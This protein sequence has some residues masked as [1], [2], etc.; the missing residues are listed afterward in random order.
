EGILLLSLD[1]AVVH[2]RAPNVVYG[3][4]LYE[5]SLIP[6]FWNGD[7]TFLNSRIQ[8]RVHEAAE[9]PAPLW[10]GELGY[11]L[12]RPG[13]LGYADAALTRA[14]DLR[15]GWAWWQWREN[16]YWGIVDAAGRIANREALRHLARPY[17]VAAPAGVRAGRGDGLR[18]RLGLTI[19]RT[20]ADLPVVISW[21]AATLGAPAATG[22]CLARSTWDA[23]AA[24]LTLELEPAVACEVSITAG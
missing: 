22:S 16:R 17:L 7:P 15:I 1:T 3:T 24:R 21:S 18:G 23:G 13:A 5:G 2:L 9:V 11:D 12:T 19:D 10:I 20:H 8:Q 4:H 6:P 14:D